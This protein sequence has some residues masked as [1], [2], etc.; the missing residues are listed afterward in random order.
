[1]ALVLGSTAGIAATTV[2]DARRGRAV[3]PLFAALK[4][5][6]RRRDEAAAYEWQRMLDDVA[7]IWGGA[8]ERRTA[9]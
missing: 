6:Q 3:D 5:D 9:A 4:A 2:I 8:D 7:E 1:M